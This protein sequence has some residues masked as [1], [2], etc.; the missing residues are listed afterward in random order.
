MALRHYLRP[1]KLV[2]KSRTEIGP[3]VFAFDFTPLKPIKWQAG[4]HGSL[5]ITMPSGRKRRKVFSIASAPGENIITIATRINNDRPDLF[6]K[7]LLRQKRGAPAKLRGPI[8]PMRI[9]NHAKQYALLATGVGITPFRSILKQLAMDGIT[10]I[11]VTLFYVGDKDSHFFKEDFSEIKTILKNVSL[12]YIY[13]PERI[14][15]QI[16]EEKL[17]KELHDTIFLLAG[18][19]NMVRSYRR[20]LQGLGVKRKAIKSNPFIKKT[21]KLPKVPRLKR[22]NP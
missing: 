5:E 10:D 12:E 15:G 22:A 11:K 7:A 20:T 4:Q 3:G 13:K 1:H 6:K 8:G 9:K 18:P 21:S 2:L 14:T 17:G 16:L 19:P